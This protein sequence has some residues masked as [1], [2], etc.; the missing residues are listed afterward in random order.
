MALKYGDLNE[1]KTYSNCE[2]LMKINEHI[3]QMEEDF[4][5][6]CKK[7]DID[8]QLIEIPEKYQFTDVEFIYGCHPHYMNNLLYTYM[9]LEIAKKY[10]QENSRL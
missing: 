1:L 9:G 5:K 3:Q 6:K 7:K 10:I 4:F 2:E 8:V